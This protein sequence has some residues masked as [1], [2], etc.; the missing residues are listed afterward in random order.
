[1]N[2]DPTKE[3]IPLRI[4]RKRVKGYKMPYNSISVTRP[5]RFGNPFSVEKYGRDKAVELFERLFTES[6]IMNFTMEHQLDIQKS[7]FWQYWRQSNYMSTTDMVVK[8]LAGKNI[9]CFCKPDQKCHGDT[10]IK[11][12]NQ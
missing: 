12:A 9:A 10:Y 7:K 5:G 3:R 4:Q 1:M 6:H 2:L 8:E 11:I